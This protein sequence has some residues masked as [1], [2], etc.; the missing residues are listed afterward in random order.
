MNSLDALAGVLRV[1]PGAARPHALSGTR[2]DWAATLAR[3]RP[4]HT[5]PTLL[6]AVFNLCSHAHRQCARAAVDAARGVQPAATGTLRGETLREHLRRVLI[7]WP[8]LSAS[9]VRA[10]AQRA[11][12]TCPAL[13]PDG[14]DADM[15]G[16]LQ[17]HLLGAEPARWLAACRRDPQ[18]ALID[19]RDAAPS[20]LA[21][22]L[23]DLAPLADRPLPADAPLHVHADDDALRALA[24]A[25]ARDPAFS[26]RPHLAGRCAETGCWTRLDDAVL[27]DSASG[28]LA[29]RLVE[30]VTLALPGGD[31]RLRSGHVVLAPGECL[32][33]A[34]MARGLLVHH[35]V[36][37]GQGED[38]RIEACHVLAPTEWNVH[39]DGAVARALEALEPDAPDVER[40]VAILMAAWDPCVRYQTGPAA[41]AKELAHA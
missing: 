36:L 20:W 29:A 19:W 6:G 7:D 40:Q 8:A 5:L 4:A 26:R 25:L 14:G 17:R 41:V 33:W 22:L 3:G 27:P 28:R 10:D 11:L 12:S 32:A 16:W 15:A 35:V 39:P 38:A 37:D 31:R 23:R 13:R 18:R 24:R 30:L 9:G 21:R 34:E 1:Q 2:P